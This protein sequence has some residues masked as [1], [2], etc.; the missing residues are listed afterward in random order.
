M[1]VCVC[2]VVSVSDYFYVECLLLTFI[3]QND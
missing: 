1:C 3:T 2:V